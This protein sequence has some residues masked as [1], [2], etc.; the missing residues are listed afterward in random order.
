MLRVKLMSLAIICGCFLDLP[1]LVEQ[2]FKKHSGVLTQS[3]RAK[4]A[5]SKSAKIEIGIISKYLCSH[6]VGRVTLPL[7]ASLPRDRF[8]V[9]VFSFP[10]KVDSWAQA[11]AYSADRYIGL[12]NDF[13]EATARIASAN[14]DII[15]YP[16]FSD[17][18]T[19]LLSYQVS[20]KTK[21]IEMGASR[22]IDACGT[23]WIS[24]PAQL[25]SLI[26]NRRRRSTC[27]RT[28]SATP[29]TLFFAF[30]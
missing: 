26:L 29:I 10:T 14:L 6:P 9:T 3:F 2:S 23:Y 27:L 8:R 25:H 5:A 18:I 15:L 16:D 30:V 11:I 19:C 21:T 13:Q 7:V 20:K 22:R 4:S 17:E 1:Q 28:S 12:K 24:P